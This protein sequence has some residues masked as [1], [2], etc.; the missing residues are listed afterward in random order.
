MGAFLATIMWLAKANDLPAYPF[1]HVDGVGKVIVVPDIGEIDFDV[2]V[3]A[4]TAE[5][6]SAQVEAR[7]AAVRAVLEQNGVALTDMNVLGVR[8]EKHK[9]AEGAAPGSELIDVKCVVTINV[10]ELVKWSAVLAPL[11][12]MADMEGFSVAF[13]TTEHERIESE[14]VIEAVANA[15]KKAEALLAGLGRKLGP[16]AGVTKGE[17]KNLTRAMG[18]A[19]SDAREYRA[20]K[21]AVETDRGSLLM[22]NSL[23]L[24]QSVD[25]IFRIK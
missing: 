19:A 2:S 13:D 12:D 16:V 9:L 8:K 20:S 24:A 7:L 17:L 23:K 5:Q 18:L 6:A 11:L 14:L 15:R 21:A 22:I 10:R 4:P 3:T 1:V 25:V